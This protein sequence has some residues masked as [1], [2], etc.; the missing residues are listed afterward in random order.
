MTQLRQ[1]ILRSGEVGR[2]VSDDY[3]SSIVQAPLIDRDPTSGEAL[4]Y[5]QLSQSLEKMSG[6]N[7]SSFPWMKMVNPQSK[8]ISSV[9][10]RLSATCWT[11]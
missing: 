3:R 6:R 7:T 11:A 2:L 8:Y 5:W 1:N 9:S 10:P 4:N